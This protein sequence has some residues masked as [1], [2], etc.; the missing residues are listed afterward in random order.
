[1]SCNIIIVMFVFREKKF[2]FWIFYKILIKLQTRTDEDDEGTK[3]KKKF[4]VALISLFLS[5]IL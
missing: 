3:S 2:I 1:M 4:F 5:L